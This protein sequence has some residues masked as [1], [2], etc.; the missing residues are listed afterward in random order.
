ME[1]NGIRWANMQN[2]INFKEHKEARLQPFF[3]CDLCIVTGSNGK[4][5]P[6]IWELN[7]GCSLCKMTATRFL[8]KT[9]RAALSW[10]PFRACRVSTAQQKS[11]WTADPNSMC[12]FLLW[13]AL[14]EELVVNNNFFCHVFHPSRLIQALTEWEVWKPGYQIL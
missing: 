4:L 9:P 5:T 13:T 6:E 12:A 8:D 2:P 14:L 7:V 11:W 1:E 3:L 10:E